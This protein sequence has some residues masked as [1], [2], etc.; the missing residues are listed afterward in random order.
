MH[1]YR[2]AICGITSSPYALRSSAEKH[3]ANHR[4]RRH[5]G[6]R[7]HPDGERILSGGYRG[8]RGGEWAAVILTIG[9]LAVALL[10]KV[11]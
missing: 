7:N 4:R 2:C 8:P 6:E 1:R 11:F 3:G 9:L 5:G 10:G